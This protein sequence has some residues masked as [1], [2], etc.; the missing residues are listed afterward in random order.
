MLVHTAPATRTPPRAIR[1]LNNG[2]L[3][4]KLMFPCHWR[5]ARDQAPASPNTREARQK[6]RQPATNRLRPRKQARP[7]M[8]PTQGPRLKVN[9]IPSSCTVR[10]PAQ[11]PIGASDR[12]HCHWLSTRR[13]NIATGSGMATAATANV[14]GIVMDRTAAVKM[15]LPVVPVTRREPEPEISDKSKK[16]NP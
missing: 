1:G 12:A 2:P 11:R 3:F 5:K 9:M 8:V 10:T 6:C 14:A 4:K 13:P 16:S 15:G 7:T